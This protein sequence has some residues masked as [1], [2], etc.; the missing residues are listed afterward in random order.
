MSWRL[1]LVNKKKKVIL[2]KEVNLHFYE[3]HFEI[4]GYPCN[5]IG[6]QGCDLFTNRTI[7]CSKLHLFLSKWEW[8]S[9]T[10]Q[11]T[12]FEGFLN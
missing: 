8:D 3:I 10:K 4:T 7:F 9:K 11:P 5:V 12:I 2:M 6:S 1:L